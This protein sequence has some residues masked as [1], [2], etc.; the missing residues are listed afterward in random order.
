MKPCTVCVSYIRIR[1]HTNDA[2]AASGGSHAR[3]E[4]TAAATETPSRMCLMC[5]F[6]GLGLHRQAT[7]QESRC[8]VGEMST[9]R[10]RNSGDTRYR[11]D[12]Y[13]RPLGRTR[14]NDQGG[15]SARLGLRL[16]AGTG[17]GVGLALRGQGLASQE[18]HHLRISSADR[19]VPSG[20]GSLAPRPK[21][22][23]RMVISPPPAC[24]RRAPPARRRSSRIR[25]SPSRP[26]A[27]PPASS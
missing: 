23:R 24:R 19:A 26:S 11:A 16:A 27:R 17:A 25:A 6:M 20:A 4:A 13:H 14:R 22:A 9:Y 12:A 5:S 3:T 21:R 2:R 10:L 15:S 1:V 8:A 18:R 7:W